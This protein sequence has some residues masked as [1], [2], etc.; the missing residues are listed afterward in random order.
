MW[1]VR[2]ASAWCRRLRHQGDRRGGGEPCGDRAL[3]CRRPAFVLVL[4]NHTT[5]SATG[6]GDRLAPTVAPRASKSRRV[7]T[8]LFRRILLLFMGEEDACAYCSSSSDHHGQT[9]RRGG[10][11][12][13]REYAKFAASTRDAAAHDPDLDAAA[14]SRAPAT[15]HA[16]FGDLRPR[17]IGQPSPCGASASGRA[18]KVRRRSAWTRSAVRGA[19]AA[20]ARRRAVWAPR[21]ILRRLCVLRVRRRRRLGPLLVWTR[22]RRS[23]G[24]SRPSRRWSR[25]R[26][27]RCGLRARRSRTTGSTARRAALRR[28]RPLRGILAVLGL[29]AR[30]KPTSRQAARACARRSA[31]QG[32]S[33]PLMVGKPI[34]VGR[35]VDRQGH[36]GRIGRSSGARGDH[37]PRHARRVFAARVRLSSFA[38][39]TG[40]DARGRPPAPSDVRR[41][42]AGREADGLVVE[43][44]SLR[45]PD[46]DG[47]ETLVRCDLVK[48]AAQEGVDAIARRPTRACCSEPRTSDLLALSGC[49]YSPFAV[50]PCV[51][52]RVSRRAGEHRQAGTARWGHHRRPAVHVQNIASV[53][54][55]STIRGE[56]RAGGA[57]SA[58]R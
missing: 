26:M 46:D 10:E 20:A 2:R 16:E 18:S 55:P 27:K 41:R 24:S 19:G 17:S 8:A 32:R 21:A 11:G 39:R 58:R 37:G 35:P 48:S 34:D 14:A 9:G 6:F 22:W 31:T 29:P 54:R 52:R 49:S 43:L 4:E 12:L 40:N 38:R 47:S 57:A 33:S 1:T 45:R 13:L 56:R 30:A 15:S 5:R 51:R 23:R 50:R 3:I 42:R 7:G 28:D 25:P 53:R 44:I 36:G